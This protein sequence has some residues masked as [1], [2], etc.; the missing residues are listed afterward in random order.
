MDAIQYSLG[1]SPVTSSLL[2]H[3]VRYNFDGR[4]LALSDARISNSIGNWRPYNI[5]D[6]IS[7]QHSTT[8]TTTTN[9]NNNFAKR[10]QK[11]KTFRHLP[12]AANTMAAKN[13]CHAYDNDDDDTFG[14]FGRMD[15]GSGAQ[16]V[17]SI[18]W[19]SAE[20]RALSGFYFFVKIFYDVVH[21]FRLL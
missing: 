7:Q 11:P 21:K 9:D 16:Y 10:E 18:K 1:M 14:R 13:L 19:V 8:T 15:H 3:S 20:R 17:I 2:F 12:K 6:K 4:R 5:C